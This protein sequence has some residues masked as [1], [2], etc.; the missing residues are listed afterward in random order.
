MSEKAKT[1]KTK[2]RLKSTKGISKTIAQQ[3]E[4]EKKSPF[5]E[6]TSALASKP[7]DKTQSQPS[8]PKRQKTSREQDIKQRVLAQHAQKNK[9]KK[10]T[11]SGFSGRRQSD[12]EKPAPARSSFSPSPSPSKVTFETTPPNTGAE[13]SKSSGRDDR[14]ERTDKFAG[15]RGGGK[16][17]SQMREDAIRREEHDKFFLEQKKGKGKYG[18]GK[19]GGQRQSS[20]TPKVIKITEYI[21]VGELARKL[22]IKATEVISKLMTMGEMVTVNQSID[23]ETAT[24][25]A[26][27]YGTEV[28]V[29]SLYEETVIQEEPD[30]E[31]D[32]QSRPPVV[33]IMGH[34]D[35]GKTKLL[36]ALRQ[37]D[38]VS[39]E[40]GGITQHIGAYQVQTKKGKITFLDTPGHE[41]FTAMRAR[42]AQ[43]TDIVV[44]V[45]A[46]NDGVMPQTIEAI[47]HAR[48]AGVPLIVAI[49][50]IDSADANPEK[51]R[52]QLM[53]RNLIPEELG[54]DTAFVEISALKK[55]NLDKLED[56]IL[57]LA[58]I[59]ELK[60]N[61]NKKA[62]G[63]VVEAKLDQGRGSVAT[64]LISSGTLRQGDP[65]VVGLE[66]GKV[67]ALIN[68]KGQKIT[69]ATPATPVEILGLSGVPNAGDPFHV[70]DSEKETKDIIEK[71]QELYR[72]QQAQSIKKVKLEN[73]NQVIE[74]GKI[75]ELKII[76]KADVKGSA[77]ALQN[78]L[79]KLNNDE[80]RVNIIYMSTGE[81]NES[82]VMLASAGNAIILAFNTRANAR[83]KEIASREGVEI[84]AYSIIYKA[85]E[86]IEAALSGM[87]APEISEE[88]TGEL[89]IRNTFKISTVGTVGGCMVISGIVKRNSKIRLFRSGVVVYQGKLKSLKRFQNDAAEVKEGYECGILIEGYNDIKEGDIVEAYEE[90]E[91]SRDLKSS[92]KNK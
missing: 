71:R 51:V 77:E 78:S 58:E 57:T 31:K 80:V 42:G 18:G 72:Q 56:H 9:A 38:I 37:T 62:N 23:K 4:E 14:N 63:T 65:Y 92:S 17:S 43:V 25:V 91:I 70:M 39:G 26:S 36:D 11:T 73:L 27:E 20:V 10:D 85:I 61:Y 21:Q 53:E 86:E 40:A 35:H 15:K 28:Q 81:I 74:E 34:V 60:A 19:D 8:Q 69:E 55:I 54:G 29:I 88:V 5:V 22:N 79:E 48:D 16:K 50:K 89:E 68:D 82:D 47:S 49:N 59:L 84:K 3:Q 45:V 7:R 66:G 32:L 41:A 24:L 52:N 67:R 46:A 2:I 12:G 83:V 13:K 64:I 30:E 44:L 6:A 33:T 90:K 87:L 75:L 76:I 1:K